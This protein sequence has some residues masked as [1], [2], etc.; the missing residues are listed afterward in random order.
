MF[1]HSLNPHYFENP[2]AFTYLLRVVLGLWGLVTDRTVSH[3]FQRNPASVYELISGSAGVGARSFDAAAVVTAGW[4][5]PIG[6]D[7]SMTHRAGRHP[8]RRR[9]RAVAVKAIHTRT[10]WLR[11]LLTPPLSRHRGN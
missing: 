9:V 10:T 4:A 8:L 7:G 2:P 6:D 5:A 3:E 1:G 11:S